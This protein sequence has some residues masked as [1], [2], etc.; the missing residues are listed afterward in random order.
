MT[1]R[2]Q[3]FTRTPV[4]RTL[5]KNLGLPDPA[6]LPRWTEGAPVV[7][8][9]VVFGSIAETDTGKAIQAL[10]RDIGASFSTAAEGVASSELRPKALVFD[11]TGATSTA[12]LSSLQRFF[13]PVIRQL[14][15]AGRVIVVGRT[16][17]LAASPEQQIAQRALEGFTRSLGKE[18]K[19]GATVNL[20]YV[21]PDAHDQLDSTLRFFLSPKSA[22]VDGQVARIGTGPL[23][24]TDPAAPLAGKVALVTGA[25]RGI[26]AAIAQILARDGAT[27]MG[28][29]VPQNAN[30][31][32][33]VMTA[34][35]GSELLLDVTAIDAPQRIAAHAE[36]HHGGLGIVV[37]N[38]GITRDKRLA[39]MR[40]DTWDAVLDV[41]LRAPERITAHLLESGALHDGGSVIGVSSIAGI[42]GNNG[43]TN[44]ATSKAGVI[45][46]VQAYA[47]RLAERQI[48]INAVAPGFIETEMTARVPFAIREVG[49]RINSLQQGGQPVDVAETIAWFAD[50]ASAGVTGNV[51]RVCGQSMLGA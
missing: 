20:V 39:N 37:H 36:E 51:V 28:V 26:G 7:D 18:V 21:A 33:Q 42:A 12:D 41:N 38:A 35:G 15:A 16:P 19:R 13:S 5:V 45:G 23:V 48:R 1:D 43:Q 22:Y 2:Y 31:L 34:I 44:Y 29:D 4:G 9:P 25:A 27:V 3:T 46:L 40:T 17:E 8:G 11:A 30:D 14:G 50:P 6:P 49:R 10:L 32:R 47:P 24:A